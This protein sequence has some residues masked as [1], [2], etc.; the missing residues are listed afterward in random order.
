MNING[1]QALLQELTSGNDL[2]AES[3]AESISQYGQQ[4]VDE[5]AILLQSDQPDSRWWAV[6]ALAEFSS[7]EAAALLTQALNDAEAEVQR[8]AALALHRQPCPQAV[9][10]LITLLDSAD[11]LLARLAANALIACGQQA[12]PALLQVIRGASQAARIE[13]A[14]VLAAIGDQA[15]I[16]TL[17]NLLDEDSAFLEYWAN[18]G[19]ESMGIGMAFFSPK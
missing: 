16:S 3:A 2:S 1:L 6:R 5:L 8:C 14:R 12:T 7:Q 9:P 10:D 11:R 17:F 13:A 18:Q 4:A 15:S 19:L